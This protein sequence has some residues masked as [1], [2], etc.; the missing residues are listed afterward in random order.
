MNIFPNGNKDRS[1]QEDVR[2][3]KE[4]VWMVDDSVKRC[5]Y[6][7]GRVIQVFEGDDCVVRSA[8]FKKA[9]E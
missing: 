3:L 7:N 2:I 8:R 1:F 4:L 6:R 5:E 9:Y